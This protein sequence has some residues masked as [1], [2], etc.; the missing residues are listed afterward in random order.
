MG[1]FRCAAIAFALGVI[2]ILALPASAGAATMRADPPDT[3]ISSLAAADTSTWLVAAGSRLYITNDSGKSWQK[4]AEFFFPGSLTFDGE[5]FVAISGHT[6]INGFTRVYRISPSGALSGRRIPI[7]THRDSRAYAASDGTV[8][9]ASASNS[10]WNLI[11]H[12]P[13]GEWTV[14]TTATSKYPVRGFRWAEIGGKVLFTILTGIEPAPIWDLS[15]GEMVEAT[16][17]DAILFKRGEF[18]LGLH[19]ISHDGGRTFFMWGPI[20]QVQRNPGSS[21]PR[22]LER[23]SY[24]YEARGDV[25]LPA[26]PISLGE[27]YRDVDWVQTRD[28]IV[29]SGKLKIYW[30]RDPAATWS[31]AL[32]GMPADSQAMLNRFNRLQADAGFEPFYADPRISQAARNHAHW[33]VL[34]GK[35]DHGE[36]AGTPGFTGESFVDRC[37]AM[38]AE[39]S[40]EILSRGESDSASA[41]DGWATTPYHRLDPRVRVIGGARNQEYFGANTGVVQNIL[42]KPLGFPRGIWRG[43]LGWSGNELPSPL[44]ACK[45]AG[46]PVN[47]PIGPAITFYSPDNI[48]SNRSRAIK[49]EVVSVRP[50]GGDPLKG[51]SISPRFIP[52]DPLVAGATY[53]VV[54]RWQAHKDAPIQRVTWRFRTQPDPRWRHTGSTDRSSLTRKPFISKVRFRP[55]VISK[56][57]RG[58][59]VSTL[60]YR[61]SRRARVTITV[62]RVET[63]R[64]HRGSC[65]RATPTNRARPRCRLLTRAAVLRRTQNAGMKRIKL[66]LRRLRAGTYEIRVTARNGHGTGRARPARFRVR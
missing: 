2:C 13:D 48:G 65:M 15:G 32:A 12:S 64:R 21:A 18:A 44:L 22:L 19:G 34:N 63:G 42:I 37:R 28:G 7:P 38:G 56:K 16:S 55:S 39:C 54:A 53:E 35:L 46:Q 36:I 49:P 23:G 4:V 3:P 40:M 59:R 5:S 9:V 8:Y 58:R 25:I 66:P 57:N 11:R 60:S 43:P 45:S 30:D 62:L 51:C 33:M 61:L 17:Q 14:L 52:E 6:E 31:Q 27:D 29:G 41:V 24:L 26:V 20:D 50:V 1:N 47:P 10:N